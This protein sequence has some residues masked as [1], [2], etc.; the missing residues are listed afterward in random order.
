[1]CSTPTR[2][3]VETSVSAPVSGVGLGVALV[4]ARVTV[5]MIL[6][7]LSSVGH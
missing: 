4:S 5:L 2:S 6:G 1:M 3:N 7:I